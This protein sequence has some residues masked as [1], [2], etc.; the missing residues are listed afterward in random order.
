M[1]TYRSS[2]G[3]FSERPFY[4]PLDVDRMCSDALTQNR[5]MPSEPGPVRIDRFVEKHFNLA[6]IY[7]SIGNGVLGFTTFGD[8]GVESMHIDEPS[9]KN[10]VTER[11]VRSTLAHEAGHGLMH[12]HL[13]CPEFGRC[14]LFGS[15]PDV[16]QEKV[17]CREP[18][19][20][21]D[22]RW[23]ELQA[24]MAI[25]ALLMPS[26]L[27]MIAMEPYLERRG[28]FQTPV[29]DDARRVEAISAMCDVFEVNN[30]VAR[31]RVEN[32][33]KVGSE[34]QLTL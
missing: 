32:F 4:S 9:D 29:L 7:E 12:A 23:W 27:M 11:R 8:R 2:S 6:V 28:F 19:S 21:Y 30:P 25:G 1:R 3:L 10:K 16:S 34:N 26:E 13:F 22:G 24:N 33:F 20:G 15:D 14:S 18:R 31:I 5:L 17:L